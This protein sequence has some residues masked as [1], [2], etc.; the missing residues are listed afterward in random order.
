METNRLGKSIRE[1]FDGQY[2][3]IVPLYQR[4]FAWRREEIEQ[5][6][7]DVYEAYSKTGGVGNYY[8]GSLVVLKRTNGDFEVIDGQQRLTTLSLITKILGINEE[9]RLFYDSRPE[10]EEFFRVFYES[11]DG[12][13]NIDYPQTFHLKNTIDYIQETSLDASGEKDIKISDKDKIRSFTNYFANNVILVRVEIPQDTDV[14]SYFEIMNNRGEQLQKHEILKSFLLSKLSETDRNKAKEF[15]RIW[16]ACSQMDI[17][18]QKQFDAETRRRYFGGLYEDFCFGQL[19][20]EEFAEE[21]APSTISKILESQ[22]L[23]QTVIPDKE[24][25]QDAD[26]SIYKSIIDF[27]N[28]LMHVIKVMSRDSKIEIPLNEKYLLSKYGELKD[29]IDPEKFIYTLFRCRTFFDRYVIKTISDKTDNEDGEKW[30]LRKPKYYPE[31]NTWKYV[32][33]F[34]K[35]DGKVTSNEQSRVI[36][37]LSMLQVSFRTRIYKNW[38]YEILKWFNELKRIDVS[39]EEYITK[40][41]KIILGNFVG[42]KNDKNEAYSQIK[43]EIK[44]DNSYSLGTGTPHFLFNLIDYLYWVDSKN[45]ESIFDN[46]KELKDFNF[47]YWNSVE[48]HMA[49]EWAERNKEKFPNYS[50]YIDNIGNLCLI[51]KSANS[52]LSDRDVKEKVET[53]GRGNLGAN[54]QL[55]Y[56]MTKNS[57]NTYSWDESKIRVHYNE[58]LC[59]LSKSREILQLPSE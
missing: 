45:D 50:D 49:R 14:A 1:I 33:T 5:L 26:E 32:D 40:L 38:L 18:I 8:I 37:A 7:Q 17:P 35:D 22:V 53:F 25:E 28:F 58:L 27:P 47:K 29:Q 21:Q 4:N 9:P 19:N 52:R 57:D 15:A 16:D 56:K 44:K 43:E 23:T 6:L 42:L 59:L 10:V 36:K 41:D 2:K 20:P 24:D 12:N 39:F 48:H 31:T 34:G 30:T 46:P 55:M 54:R 51:S 3:Y 13:C 11:S